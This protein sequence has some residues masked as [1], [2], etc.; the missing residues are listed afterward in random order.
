MRTGRRL[1]ALVALAAAAVPGC[2]R[3]VPVG[4]EGYYTVVRN[5]EA[6]S[7]DG[8]AVAGE[9]PAGGARSKVERGGGVQY[10]GYCEEH[11]RL[12]GLS[13]D[14]A[15][16]DRVVAVHNALYH[17]VAGSRFWVGQTITVADGW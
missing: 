1:L 10:R 5:L 11:G 4:G 17:N 9:G 8:V 3:Q 12:T 7:P 14:G 2:A 16:V 13:T 15:T 6:R